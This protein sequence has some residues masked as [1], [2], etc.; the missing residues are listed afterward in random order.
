[1]EIFKK[2][3]LTASNPFSWPLRG[4]Y[5]Q[6][7]SSFLTSEALRRDLGDRKLQIKVREVWW[8]G[9]EVWCT[10]RPQEGLRKCTP[11]N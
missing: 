4:E 2:R 3:N 1:M 5:V 9:P 8:R 7:D 6:P 10:G 11:E